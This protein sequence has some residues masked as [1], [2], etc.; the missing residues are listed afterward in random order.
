MEQKTPEGPGKNHREGTSLKKLFKMLPDDDT[1]RWW[2]EKARWPDGPYCPV[3]RSYNVQ[4]NIKHKT[5]THRCRACEKKTMFS[6]K[7]GTVMQSSKLGYQAWAIAIYLFATNLKGV[8]SMKL[9]R[10]LDIAQK[11]AWH[12]AHRLRKAFESE[13]RILCRSRG[14]R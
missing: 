8:S 9:H 5:M 6:V 13:G 10:D 2:F 7:V 3:C 12:L 1:A 14:G 4:E 11:K